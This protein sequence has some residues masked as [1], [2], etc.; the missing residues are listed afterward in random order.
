MTFLDLSIQ[1]MSAFFAIGLLSYLYKDNLA[2]KFAEYTLLGLSTGVTLFA[3]YNAIMKT[4]VNAVI[5]GRLIMIVPLIL[6]VLVFTRFSETYNWISFL[7]ISIIIG[8]GIG[9]S[10]RGAITGQFIDQIY[11]TIKP[12]TVQQTLSQNVDNLIILIGT[13]SALSYFIF[14]RE[15]EGIF[16]GVTKVGKYFLMIAMGAQF[17]AMATTFLNYGILPI[18]LAVTYP[19]YYLSAIAVLI[20]LAD[21]FIPKTK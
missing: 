20:V 2:F 15:Q 10:V 19:G 5:A 3:G 9:L 14:T 17:G 12:L 21:L 1:L 4:G 18:T 8:I 11:A 6:G 7:P 16:G 13:V